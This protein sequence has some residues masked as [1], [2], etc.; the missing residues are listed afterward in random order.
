MSVQRPWGPRHI[1]KVGPTGLLRVN[2]GRGKERDQGWH[3]GTSLVAQWLGLHASTA[4]DMGVIPGWGT[5]IL[6]ATWCGNKKTQN[7][8]G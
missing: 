3:Q 8:T 1:L 7:K 4:G 6:R 5:K 2:V